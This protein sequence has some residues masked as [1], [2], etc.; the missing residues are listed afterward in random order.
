VK[1]P[2]R[3]IAIVKR[4][5]P[6]SARRP[7]A[8]GGVVLLLALVLGVGLAQATAPTVTIEPVSNPGYVTADVKGTVDPQGQVTTWQFQYVT[9]EQFDALEGG[10]FQ[11]PSPGP[12]GC[13]NGTGAAVEGCVE[14]SG[15]QE[16]SGTLNLLADTE[17]HFLLVATNGDGR[18]EKIA[19]STFETKEVAK[20]VVTVA[21]AEGADSSSADVSGTVSV[22]NEDPAF[23]AS[24]SFEYATQA[25][26][27]AE[28]FPGHADCEPAI[29]KG[30]ELQPVNVAAHLAGLEPNAIYHLRLR[31]QNAGGGATASAANTFTT[32]AVAPEPA[33]WTNTP[34]KLGETLV[35][36]T[37]NPHNSEVTECR[38]EY[39]LTA[40]YG[41]QVPC[42][43][44]IGDGNL[45]VDVTAQIGGLAPGATYH[46][47][48]VAAS[49][50]G[51]GESEDGPFVSAQKESTAPCPNEA[52]RI[53]QHST[54][55]PD[56]RAYEMVSP[57]SKNGGDVKQDA[58]RVRAAV[59]G[60]AVI[61]PSL[62]GF[63]DAQGTSYS[64]DYLAERTGAPGASG[65]TTHGITPPQDPTSPQ[66]ISIEPLYTGDLSPDLQSGV[67]QSLSPVT[68]E[69]DVAGV[70]NLYERTDLRKS[71]AGTYQLLT[72]CP[73]CAQTGESLPPAVLFPISSLPTL[74]GT[75]TD[76]GHVIFESR[77]KLT[78]DAPGNCSTA[79][80]PGSSP[81]NNESQCPTKLYES[82]HGVVRLAGILPDGTAAEGSI[83]GV[84]AG[85]SH[86]GQA[87]QTPHTI[88][89]DGRRIF[90]TV[91]EAPR[92]RFGNLY[93]RVDN[94]EPDAATVQIN[95]SERSPA[96][97][98]PEGTQPAQY[99][100][101]SVD[102]GRVFFTT[103]EALTDNA[104]PVTPKI[105]MYDTTK[106][107]SDP[108]NLTLIS[109]D[110]QPVDF[111]N[112][113]EEGFIGASADGRYAYFLAT[114]Q[115]D[116]HHGVMP[117]DGWGF[118]LW[119]DEGGHSTVRLIAPFPS[120]VSKT[121]Q[122]NDYPWTNRPQLARVSPDG[123]H[124]LFSEAGSGAGPTGY[125]QGTCGFQAGPGCRV[126]YAYDADTNEIQCVSCNS[127]GGPATT[128]ATDSIRQNGSA[129]HTTGY[130]N[131]PLAADGRRAFFTTSEAL[132][133]R[134]I[135]GTR[136]VYE[137][138]SLTASVHLISSGTDHQESIFLDASPSGDDVFFATR[139]KL[140]G[141]DPDTNFDLYDARVGGGFAEP[142][143]AAA[144]CSGDSCHGAVAAQPSPPVAASA[145]IAGSG[146]RAVR[147]HKHH[148]R[149]H[150]KG[151]HQH[152]PKPKQRTAGNDRRAAR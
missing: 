21:D 96:N 85:T 91:P 47:R 88:S 13:V 40:S 38:F 8:V 33:T 83:A 35:R 108:H 137:Y 120:A 70:P 150:R 138:D 116:E 49:G 72:T 95:A 73:V 6:S 84:G 126:F 30:G 27:D 18:T 133:P 104:P 51:S 90:F 26:F 141:W 11:N 78:A 60:D 25:Q 42:E 63:G 50:A 37:L 28:Q 89:A 55:L 111:N 109:V 59:D 53:E 123:R 34:L 29:V 107:A 48:I 87:Y 61:F 67:F 149:H 144:G 17:Y 80:Q 145:G 146:N 79:G 99:D 140:E 131:H 23:D 16:V 31:A 117:Q 44:S 52:I 134:D 151:K 77:Q 97:P 14:A 74:A 75:A 110:S 46:F 68:D 81:I 129:S 45:P 102:G 100:D 119:H 136:D 124:L 127:A 98:D 56:C 113:A 121:D 36:G 142:A 76:R 103:T 118:Y 115:L 152:A 3:R 43:G 112:G 57:A 93:M 1:A 66:A 114:G 22:A 9:D 19:A 54:Y 122:R 15:P 132:V 82:D 39:G 71:G 143:A 147:R 130:L 20:P 135:N 41:S 24:C 105:Y 148:R 94:G 92:G 64:S 4:S 69:P 10:E 128:D 7:L 32:D 58:G 125:D 65:W 12:E 86:D 106:P 5:E 2:G 139:S 101:A 62:V